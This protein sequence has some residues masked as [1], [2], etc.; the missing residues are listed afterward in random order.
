[1]PAAPLDANA[2]ITNGPGD[3]VSDRLPVEVPNAGPDG[4]KTFNFEI[5]DS[6]KSGQKFS[7]EELSKEL[8]NKEIGREE[9]KTEEGEEKLRDPDPKIAEEAAKLKAEEEA[10]QKALE[11]KQAAEK[12]QEEAAKIKP[13]PTAKLPKPPAVIEATD[14]EYKDLGIAETAIPLLK[15]ASKETQEF[16]IAELRRNKTA[17][18]TAK[19]EAETAKKSVRE[20][21]PTAWYEHE[22]A[23]M[24]T[25]EYQ[26]AVNKGTRLQE[27]AEHYRQQL[28][29][30]K[31]GEKWFDLTVGPDGKVQ[32]V[33]REP[34]S[35]AEVYALERINK[36]DQALQQETR[37]AHNVAGQFRQQVSTLRAEMQKAENEFFPQYEKEFEKNE[38]GGYVMNVLKARGQ[39]NNP[40]APFLAKLYATYVETYN[41]LE[42]ANAV[43][44]KGKKIA[45]INNGPTGEEI[46]KGNKTDVVTSSDDA[47]FDPD[48][49]EKVINRMR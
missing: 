46:A 20:G 5:F 15:K 13:P 42:A 25:P 1:M 6:I 7:K 12:E 2:L 8:F 9:V 21:L 40:I 14:K 11:A 47:P 45:A 10:S 41:E 35:A 31:D 24:L 33:Q 19:A 39:S 49:F 27:F 38:H 30:I 32:Q 36:F 22:Q 26:A 18:D 16:I 43:L 29:A 3:G 28:I 23:Y 17:L 4:D 44:N 48:A 37:I 34:G